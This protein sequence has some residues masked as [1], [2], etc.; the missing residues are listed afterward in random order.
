MCVCLMMAETKRREG[1]RGS[2][3]NREE[4]KRN[5]WR[6]FVKVATWW[7]LVFIVQDSPKPSHPSTRYGER[8][9]W[10][11]SEVLVEEC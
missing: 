6:V 4:E 3:E 9:W 11:W 7:S 2:A 8:R 5:L 10:R 1:E